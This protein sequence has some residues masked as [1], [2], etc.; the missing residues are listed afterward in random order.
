MYFSLFLLRL[1]LVAVNAFANSL[2][3]LEIESI[4]NC[5]S[6]LQI[7]RFQLITEK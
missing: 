5:I 1:S 7:R 3:R 6:R 2:F 4:Q